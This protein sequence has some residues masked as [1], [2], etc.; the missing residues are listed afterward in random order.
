MTFFII[1]WISKYSLISVLFISEKNKFLLSLIRIPLYLLHTVRHAFCCSFTY[2]AWYGK[3]YNDKWRWKSQATSWPLSTISF[4]V[5]S[6]I[7]QLRPFLSLLSNTFGNIFAYFFNDAKVTY[8]SIGFL[9]SIHSYM[10]T[11]LNFS[12]LLFSY[13]QLIDNA[14]TATLCHLRLWNRG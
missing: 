2:I 1:W 13:L 3:T 8:H 4:S 9:N 5:L 12:R 7:I 14:S 6:R 11:S 10:F